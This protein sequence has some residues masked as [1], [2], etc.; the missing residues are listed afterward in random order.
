MGSDFKD[1]QI[2]DLKAFASCASLH[3]VVFER[4]S[5]TSKA[6]DDLVSALPRC[7]IDVNGKG[8]F[9]K[10]SPPTGVT[11]DLLPLIDPVIHS[12]NGQW[13]I[14][15]GV[16]L[17]PT[18]KTMCLEVP[19]KASRAYRLEVQAE[20]VAGDD[21]LIIFL[22]VGENDCALL[23]DA[24]KSSYS[25]LHKIAGK[26]LSDQPNRYM[27]PIF[28]HRAISK[29]VVEVTAK[30]VRA[31]VDDNEVVN[32]QGDNRELNDQQFGIDAFRYT[33][34]SL[35]IGNW[36]SRFRISKLTYTPLDGA[37]GN[38]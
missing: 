32:W 33:P 5:A 2:S 9:H 11:V 8:Y 25:G 27:K 17:S 34:R 16:L 36:E 35:A 28:R 4:T 37:S 15:E 14:S 6:V 22:P 18:G 30:S 19:V 29:I 21:D 1:E 38:R 3:R 10:H 7:A 31:T 13:E 20:R 24:A 26:Q 23:L 12:R